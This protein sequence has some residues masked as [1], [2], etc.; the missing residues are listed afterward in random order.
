MIWMSEAVE[1]EMASASVEAGTRGVVGVGT[2]IGCMELA[3]PPV[4][5]AIREVI[6]GVR[7]AMVGTRA[8]VVVSAPQGGYG[9]QLMLVVSDGGT[10]CLL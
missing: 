2:V 9:H 5:A 3:S 4:I 10:A 1:D 7:V 8:D 6:V